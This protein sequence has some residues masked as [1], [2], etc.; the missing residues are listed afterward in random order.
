MSQI[1][2][3]VGPKVVRCMLM[4]SGVE[5]KGATDM[6]NCMVGGTPNLIMYL[7]SLPTDDDGGLVNT[8]MCFRVLR[9]S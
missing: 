2:E 7:T 4:N 3:I 9:E 5:E 1:A 6:S 8:A